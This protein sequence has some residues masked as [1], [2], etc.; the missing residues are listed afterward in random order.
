[1]RYIQAA[2]IIIFVVALTL[3]HDASAIASDWWCWDC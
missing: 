2:A 3:L 1:M